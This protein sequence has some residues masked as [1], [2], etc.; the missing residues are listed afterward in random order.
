MFFFLDDR[1]V[2][3]GTAG[4]I[5]FEFRGSCLYLDVEVMD[6]GRLGG[7]CFAGIGNLGFELLVLLLL[8]CLAGL[9]LANFFFGG[10]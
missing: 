7:D 4:L 8:S 3:R 10:L 6:I 9:V 2:A 5:G 1:W